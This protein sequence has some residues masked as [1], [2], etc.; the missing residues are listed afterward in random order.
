VAERQFKVDEVAAGTW[1][2]NDG[3]ANFYLRKER[4]SALVIDA[5]CRRS[6]RGLAKA[7]R[8]AN[9]AVSDVVAVLL[10]HSH[11]DHVGIA[12]RLHRRSDAAIYLHPDDNAMAFCA[13]PG[14]LGGI[15]TRL[16]MDWGLKVA[17]G[18][19]RGGC[20]P[21]PVISDL[22]AVTDGEVLDLPGRPRVIWMPGHTMGSCAFLFEGI[23]TLFTGDALVTAADRD[24]TVRCLASPAA[25]DDDPA[26]ALESV[27]R[28][29]DVQAGL[30]LP[31][32]GPDF[33][34]G[35]AVAVAQA[36]ATGV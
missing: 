11:I 7:L 23:S 33:S 2:I 17:W 35:V 36:R 21:Y 6:A 8:L 30:I 34:E 16:G 31:G 18:L 26:L 9:L 19:F 25:Y 27:D 15:K 29:A 12:E 3:L 24:G 32:H 4:T 5:G 20:L 10:T 1:R 28:L 22:T 14:F 13:T